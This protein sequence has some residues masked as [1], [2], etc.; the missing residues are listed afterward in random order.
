LNKL[1]SIT[2]SRTSDA[3]ALLRVLGDRSNGAG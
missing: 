2:T 3:S 1:L